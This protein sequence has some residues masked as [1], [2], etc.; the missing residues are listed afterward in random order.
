MGTG[1]NK[2]KKVRLMNVLVA[3]ALFMSICGFAQAQSAQLV[4]N[5]NWSAAG[6]TT[7]LRAGSDGQLCIRNNYWTPATAD[8]ACDGALKPAPKAA[9]P[10]KPIVS[11]SKV[12]LQADT[13]FD[14]DKSVIKPAGAQKLDELVSKLNGVNLEV[15][16][17]IGFTDSIGTLKYNKALS[18][19]RAEAVKAYLAKHGIETGR[20]YTEGK[21]FAEPVADNK[22]AAGR[23][24]NRR[25]VIEV[26][27]TRK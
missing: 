2:M 5:D 14:F 24:L 1:E 27:G 19:R 11:S 10:A 23:A 13:L 9:A 7:P 12:T 22:T 25:A 20:V 6:G 21:A 8:Q 16:I 4:P 3:S 18:L 26:V 15:I 17:V